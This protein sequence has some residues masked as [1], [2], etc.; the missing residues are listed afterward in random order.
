[1]S[2]YRTP[3]DVAREVCAEWLTNIHA[4]LPDEGDAQYLASIIC[5]YGLALLNEVDAMAA[6]DME[7]GNPITG[8]HYRALC[9]VRDSLPAKLAAEGGEG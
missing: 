2:N 8:A 7:A 5:A 1:V 9:K 6:A 3:E 4:P